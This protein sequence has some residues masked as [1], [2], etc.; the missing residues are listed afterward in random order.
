MEA[1][2]NKI[3]DTITTVILIYEDAESSVKKKLAV[4][5]TTELQQAVTVLIQMA[6]TIAARLHEDLRPKMSAV[7]EVIYYSE[8]FIAYFLFKNFFLTNYL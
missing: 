8:H 2:L 1:V 6:T 3:V 5:A 7:A 4:N